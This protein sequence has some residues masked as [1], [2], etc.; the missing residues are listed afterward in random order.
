MLFL[1]AFHYF[2]HYNVE[3][4]REKTHKN[5]MFSHYV[6][7]NK[8]QQRIL[9]CKHPGTNVGC[10][11]H[12]MLGLVSHKH[13]FDCFFWTIGHSLLSFTNL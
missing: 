3:E 9:L 12:I 13:C 4:L 8:G 11:V 10:A 7:H 1:T 6:F 2:R 5:S